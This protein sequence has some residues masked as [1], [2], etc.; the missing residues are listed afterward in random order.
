MHTFQWRVISKICFY[1]LQISRVAQSHPLPI[2]VHRTQR[3]FRRHGYCSLIHATDFFCLRPPTD[4]GQARKRSKPRDGERLGDVLRRRRRRRVAG[5]QG[6]DYW[7][8]ARR[9]SARGRHGDA[10][11]A[12][13]GRGARARGAE[14]TARDATHDVSIAPW[15]SEAVC[16]CL[17]ATR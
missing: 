15:H 11:C 17:W 1:L 16:R 13:G 9:R 14:R 8:Q 7:R 10:A 6:G 2:A 5:S 12:D 4:S 3:F